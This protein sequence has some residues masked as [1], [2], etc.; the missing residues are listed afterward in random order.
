VFIQGPKGLLESSGP[1]L[2]IA[3]ISASSVVGGT[4]GFAGE[5][6]GS[7]HAEPAD[8]EGK[9]WKEHLELLLWRRG[10]RRQLPAFAKARSWHL[11]DG[12]S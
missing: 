7:A 9:P 4:E 2:P 8:G 6:L 3:Q 1:S 12:P 11:G 10:T 5:T